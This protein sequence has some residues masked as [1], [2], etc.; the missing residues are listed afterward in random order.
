MPLD[1]S[2][3]QT[4]SDFAEPASAARLEAVARALAASG[5][6]AQLVAT[7]EEAK[8][9]PSCA[10]SVAFGA[11]TVIFVVGAQKIVHDLEEALVKEPLGV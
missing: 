2:Q 8:R 11:S 4:H 3:T 6:V 5:F 9:C 10:S 7:A 1:I